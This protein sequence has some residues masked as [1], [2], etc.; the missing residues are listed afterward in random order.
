MDRR[1]LLQTGLS[2][3]LAC[4][5]AKLMEDLQPKPMFRSAT[6]TLALLQGGPRVSDLYTQFYSQ[7]PELQSYWL[8]ARNRVEME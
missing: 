2:V 4:P 3:F 6:A 8:A 1:D 5:L 7:H